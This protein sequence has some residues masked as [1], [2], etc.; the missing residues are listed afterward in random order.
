M[1]FNLHHSILFRN[2]S[3]KSLSQFAESAA[4]VNRVVVQHGV[5][6]EAAADPDKS[7]T[8]ALGLSPPSESRLLKRRQ[9]QFA[10]KSMNLGICGAA[11]EVPF[12]PPCIFMIIVNFRILLPTKSALRLLLTKSD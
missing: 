7:P 3:A 11:T 9:A 2:N 4:A 10:S 1:P 12:M 8:S 6:A 5:I